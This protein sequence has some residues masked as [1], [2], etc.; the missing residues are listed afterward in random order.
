[1]ARKPIGAVLTLKDNFSATLK[2]IRRE[3]SQFRKD[4]QETRKALEK[5]YKKKL[6]LRVNN[7]AAAKK[8][9]ELRKDL[10]PLRK[11]V[12]TVF[13]YKDMIRGKIRETMNKL[14]TLGRMTVAPVIKV[15]DMATRSINR[16]KGMLG[17]TGLGALAGPAG[18]A[19]A[20]A[21]AATGA[22][23]AGTLSAGAML[24]QQQIAMRHFIGVNNRGMSSA[25]VN[26]TADA[27]LKQLR[28][29][30]NVTPFETADVI[31]AGARAINVMGGNTKDAME[32]VKVAENM[33]ALNPGKTLEQAMEAL[34][35]LKTGE[36]E[37]MKEFGFKIRAED[38][39]KAAG[40][41][42]KQLSDLTP[43]QLEAAYV[44]IVQKQIAPQFA[45]GAEK[46]SGTGSGLLSTIKGKL[47]S[48][49]A[50]TGLVMIEKLKPTLQ[51]VIKYLDSPAFAK[52]SDTVTSG[53]GTAINYIGKFVGFVKENMPQ[54]K[55]VIGGV[56]D[57]LLP[58]FTL[59]KNAVE[60][61]Y[62]AFMF[63]WPGIKAVILTVW[64]VIKPV[65]EKLRDLIGWVG[66]KIGK[67]ADWLGYKV[68]ERESSGTKAV[69]KNAYGT[70]F[71]RGGL[72]WVGE[73]GPELVNLP[74]G[75]QVIPNNKVQNY[76]NKGGNDITI[77]INGYNKSTREIMNE[78]VP[79][80]K[81]ALA[82]M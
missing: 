55:S 39:V 38:I 27:Y 68:K 13:A 37:R 77:N 47:G 62:N 3:Q 57:F 79:Q 14:K 59:L 5:A 53:I 60:L 41:K 28:E 43:E 42:G 69:G 45:G 18:I 51:G 78:L 81:L 19:L 23:G 26:Q 74:R 72:T 40:G 63:A 1:M 11:K 7:T 61:L 48:R 15:K 22:A 9:R 2:G 67:V 70:N 31:A 34:A 71:W 75:S 30:A 58:A 82:N 65:L 21:G 64:D 46:L 35:D 54:I 25:Q 32:L 36:T 56:I 73:N 4:V 8:I 12:V 33:A 10:E 24:E 52:F 17:A 80:L 49:M 76:T 50:D 29:N 66:D 6:E 44:K 16:I 20:A